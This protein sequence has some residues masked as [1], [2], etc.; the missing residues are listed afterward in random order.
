MRRAGSQAGPGF[1]GSGPEGGEGEKGMRI[2]DVV[3]GQ[4]RQ[5][6]WTNL[7]TGK[8][9][10]ELQRKITAIEDVFARG[11]WI[12]SGVIPQDCFLCE[13]R[14]QRIVYSGK[15]TILVDNGYYSYSLATH[16]RNVPMF[17]S[18]PVG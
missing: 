17:S 18:F 9:S 5:Q 10:A 4:F 13:T 6:D 7:P 11:W 8:G 2:Q 14:R 12:M 15:Q 16:F 1:S 3:I